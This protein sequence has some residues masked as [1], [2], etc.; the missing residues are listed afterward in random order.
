MV[1]PPR[2]SYVR[3]KLRGAPPDSYFDLSGFNF[4]TPMNGSRK[5]DVASAVR[6][7]V[8]AGLRG[9]VVAGFAVDRGVVCAATV[10]PNDRTDAASTSINA[11]RE[12]RIAVLLSRI[13]SS[14]WRVPHTSDRLLLYSPR[15][16]S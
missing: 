14:R 5:D 7:G 3:M 4:Q 9:V 13:R 16:G 8:A 11:R 15:S 10:V 6:A 2:S 1:P 12:S